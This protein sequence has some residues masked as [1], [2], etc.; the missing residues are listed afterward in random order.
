MTGEQS[1]QNIGGRAAVGAAWLIG[2]RLGTKLIDLTTLLLLARLLKP[3]EFGLVAVAM[4]LILIVEAILELPVNQVLVRLPTLSSR[5]FDTAFT[6]GA[7]R[8]LVLAVLLGTLAV[9]FSIVYRNSDLVLIILILGMAP[10]ARGLLSPRLAIYARH[11]DFRREFII[12]LAGKVLAFTASVI[13]AYRLQSHWALVVGIVASP[14]GMLVSS[15]IAAP[16]RPRLSLEGWRIFAG[17]L[18]WTTASQLVSAINWQCDRLILGR[19]V[20]L[21]RLG[22]FSLAND[23]AYLPEQALIKPI[24]RPLMSAFSH[25]RDDRTRLRAAY[26]KAAAAVFALGLPIMTGLSLLADPAVRLTLGGKWL[27]AVPVLQWLALSLI[28]PLFVSPLIPL[29]MALD[30]TNVFLR[31]SVWELVVKLPL[32][33]LGAAALGVTGVIGA[34]MATALVTALIAMLYVRRLIGLP[35]VRQFAGSWRIVAGGIVLAAILMALRPWLIGT[36]GLILLV[37]LAAVATL[38]FSGYLA[39]L[40]GLWAA[41][42]ASGGIEAAVVAQIQARLRRRTP[43]QDLVYLILA[44]PQWTKWQADGNFIMRPSAGSLAVAGEIG[45]VARQYFVGQRN[46]MLVEID[47]GVLGKS[48]RWKPHDRDRRSP[49]VDGPIPFAAVTRARSIDDFNT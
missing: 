3:T 39:T 26:I 9:P 31:L 49:S 21:Q 20:S 25:V 22:Q 29:A 17:F 14:V 42:G 11:L 46:L 40:F 36:D 35:L 47:L 34:R 43:R 33:L 4:T 18:G 32:M 8:G 16:Y 28:P 7:L 2:A 5:M 37:K 45:S 15:Y 12:E 24:M 6:V 48:V 44:I 30:R 13:V 41:G 19:F 38:G 10:I 1:S 27:E 23:L